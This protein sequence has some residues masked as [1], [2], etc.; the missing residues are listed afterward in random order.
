[1]TRRS[2]HPPAPLAPVARLAAVALVTAG[3]M[4][5]ALQLA[6]AAVGLTTTAAASHSATNA[7]AAADKAQ[8]LL[9]EFRMP[10]GSQRLS[11]RPATAPSRADSISFVPATPDLVTSTGWWSSTLTPSAL[12]S[13]LA[14]N[15]PKGLS[16]AQSTTRH[17]FGARSIV[18][19]IYMGQGSGA[20][21]EI[22]VFTN[23]FALPD[24]RTGLQLTALVTYRPDRPVAETLPAAARLVVTA[25]NGYGPGH[26]TG[27]T[28]VT[29]AAQIKRV[30]DLIDGLPT[31]PQGAYSCP[32]DF[33]GDLALDFD[34]AS[35]SLLAQ[36]QIHLSGCG[37]ASV[38]IGGRHEPDLSA[39]RDTAQ[40]I[41]SIIGT[42]FPLT[43]PMP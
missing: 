9:D 19:L 5:A 36:V 30:E 26:S 11:T 41:Q 7:Q 18:Q 24:G 15:P 22:A 25:S 31:A 28:T 32:A 1:M 33:G 42:H 20:V 13:W 21:D 40:Q 4:L 10:A 39:Y 27:S 43:P 35:G 2:A 17:G 23:V 38:T 29:N 34:S 16:E 8:S 14:A 37:G 12:S 3:G 6:P